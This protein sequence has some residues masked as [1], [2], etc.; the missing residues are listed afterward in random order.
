MNYRP[1]VD[2]EPSGGLSARDRAWLIVL[3]VA[4]VIVGAYFL[5]VP[6]D[7]D[8][9]EPAARTLTA[10]ECGDLQLEFDAA[11]DEADLYVGNP[12]FDTK[13]DRAN[14]IDA[15]LRAGGCYDD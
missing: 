11:M 10:R 7:D 5:I 3:A 2:E 6:S 13:I 1:V 4:A 9:D 14:A 15:Q 12:A 8:S